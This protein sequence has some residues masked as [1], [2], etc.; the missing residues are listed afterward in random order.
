MLIMHAKFYVL[1]KFLTFLAILITTTELKLRSQDIYIEPKKGD[2]LPYDEVS[3]LVIVE[4]FKY[5]YLDAIYTNNDLLYVNVEELFRPLNI[6]C[7]ANQKGDSIKGFI[8]NES[9]TYLIDY[10]K[11]QI[12][13]GAKKINAKNSMIL[14]SGSL[15]LESSLFAE[16]FGITLTFNFRTLTLMLKSSFE[17]PVVKQLRLEKLRGNISRIRGEET[18]DTTVKRDYHLFK[19]GNVD[20]SL[21]I[22]K[23]WKGYADNRFGLGIG[24]ELL[25]GEA[26]ISVNYYNQYKFDD[27]QLFYIW[28]WADNDKKLIKQA[29]VGKISNQ[30]IAFINSPVIGAVIRNSPTTVRKATGYYTISEYTEPNWTVELYINSVLVDYTKADDSGLFTFKVPIVYGYTTIKLMFYGPIGEERTEERTM[31]MP[32]TVMP[33]GEFEYGLSAGILQDSSLSRFGRAEFNYGVNRILTVGGGAEYLSSI[34]TGS[35]IPFVTTT[36]QPFSEMILTGEYASGVKTMGMMDLYFSKDA[37]LEID[38]SKYVKGQ[39]AT[40]FNALEERKVKLSIPFR[41]KKIVGFS[42]FDYSQFVYETF[43]YNQANAMFSIYYK[44]FSANSSTKLNWIGHSNLYVI[45]D[46]SLSCTLAKGYKILP[47]AQYNASENSLMSCKVSFEKSIPKGYFTFSYERD[48]LYD[49]YFLSFNFR[50]DMSFARTNFSALASNGKMFTSASAQGSMA[51]GSGNN[52]VHGSNNPSVGRGGISLYPF[53]DMNNNGIFDNGEHMVKLTSVKIA[54]SKALFNENDS[55]IRIPDL[56]S[57]TSYIVEFSNSDLD[58]IAWRFKKKSYR[59]LID[60]NQFKRIYIP[61]I[62]VGEISGTIYKNKNNSLSGIGRI[63]V[64][65]FKKDGTNAV[66]EVLSESDGFINYMG[67]EPG[68]YVAR[69]DSAQLNNLDFT[70]KPQKIDFTIKSLTDGDIV[71]GIDFVLDDKK[72]KEIERVDDVP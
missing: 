63:L 70:S 53:L 6:P 61:I 72:I 38:Y 39:L 54:G 7:I 67:L 14:E 46:L 31:N 44:Q 1:L 18:V 11:G 29:Q 55:I 4:G 49:K 50:F 62:S 71:E 15:F 33:A 34:P 12:I 3:I 59:V 41:Y 25:Y 16:A 2:A 9:R 8:E 22:N 30:T 32:Y 68:E 42:R 21:A 19:L 60:P 65:I 48:F 17:L 52:Y 66:A 47:S 13:V 36:I 24:T 26:D 35:L 64:K 57:F 56:N 20:W 45:S 40:R 69:I 51:L 23:T 58:N 37:L 27:R 5:F 10:N 28:R 43:N